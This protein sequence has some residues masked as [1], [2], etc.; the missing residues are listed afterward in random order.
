MK[1]LNK[2]LAWIAGVALAGSA[3]SQAHVATEA[4]FTLRAN[5]VDSRE[6]AEATAREHGVAP[7]AGVAVLDVVVM[8][9]DDGKA[10]LSMPAAVDATVSNLAGV[11]KSVPLRAVRRGD[12]VS[13]FGTYRHLPSEVVET[14]VTARPEGS[15]RKLTLRF[16]DKLPAY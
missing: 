7:K 3:W 4:G 10:G 12:Y 13:Y 2:A 6:L 5:V 15:A 1:H 8:R 16:K 11:R 14:T 9:N